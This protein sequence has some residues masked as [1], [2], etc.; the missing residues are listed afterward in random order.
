[1]SKVFFLE[2][3]FNSNENSLNEFLIFDV[4]YREFS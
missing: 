4:K 1:M 2:K 3:I